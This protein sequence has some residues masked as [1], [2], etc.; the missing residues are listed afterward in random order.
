MV[1]LF[2]SVFCLVIPPP[3]FEICVKK[4]GGSQ[5]E[6]FYTFFCPH[7][8]CDPH[9]PSLFLAK[10][11]TSLSSPLPFLVLKKHYPCH[12]PAKNFFFLI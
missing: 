9:H 6:F 7:M 10:K 4:R 3:L 5:R 1:D 12:P 11:N 2:L 8:P